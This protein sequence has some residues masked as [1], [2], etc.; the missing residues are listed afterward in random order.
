MVIS[1]HKMAG[2]GKVQ[3]PKTRWFAGPRDERECEK[4][5]SIIVVFHNM[6]REAKRTLYSLST[7]YQLNVCEDDYEVIAV[8]NGSTA[9]LNQH[10]VESFGRDFHYIFHETQS[11]SPVDAINIG[12]NCAKGEYVAIIVDGA[13]MASPG[14]V[15]NTIKAASLFDN[16][17][18][19]SLSWHLGPDVQNVSMLN[20]YNQKVED[21]LLQSIDWPLEGYRLFD[22]SVLAQSSQRGYLSGV[23]NELSWLC[24]A[25]RTFNELGGYDTLFQAPGGGLVNQDFL[26]RA[27]AI[28]EIQPVM[29]LGEGVF[30]Q[31]H[32][33]VATNV[34][35]ADHPLKTFNKEYEQIRGK[36]Y[37][38]TPCEDVHYFGKLS[39]AARKFLI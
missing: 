36:P 16:P 26:K 5:L 25:R 4:K 3:S 11:R 31:F 15:A 21:N 13:R 6:Q 37:K 2:K 10:F 39:T 35:M 14:V 23:P 18:V 9:P 8:D 33:G 30:H 28:P 27:L 34:P 19:G 32:G 17:L 20:G 38:P 24:L 7:E 29:L 1:I 12:V 22:I